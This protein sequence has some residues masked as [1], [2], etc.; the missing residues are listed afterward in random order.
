M[1]PL[2]KLGVSLVRDNDHRRPVLALL[3]GAQQLVLFR[4]PVGTLERCNDSVKSALAQI[5]DGCLNAVHD[6]N[7][8]RQRLQHGTEAVCFSLPGG[9][10]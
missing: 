6:I 7:P 4:P 9:H 1:K 2:G 10:V 8:N 5:V 3:Q